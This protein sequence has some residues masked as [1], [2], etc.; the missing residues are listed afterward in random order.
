MVLEHSS[1]IFDSRSDG[2]DPLRQKRSLKRYMICVTLFWFVSHVFVAKMC[3]KIWYLWPPPTLHTDLLSS[4]TKETAYQGMT[5]TTKPDWAIDSLRLYISFLAS[6]FMFSK[7]CFPS[8]KWNPFD[9][10]S[11]YGTWSLTKDTM[12]LLIPDGAS[13]YCV[14]IVKDTFN[15]SWSCC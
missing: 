12:N 7:R 9:F 10:V 6:V 15:I 5:S 8:V 3:D 13:Q 14:E 11:Y 4:Y 1:Q 2:M